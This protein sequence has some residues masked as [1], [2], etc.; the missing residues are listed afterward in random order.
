LDLLE[1][2]QAKATFF[3]IGSR[4]PGNEELLRR[5]LSEGHE[6]GNHLAE[7]EPSV[8]LDPEEFEQKLLDTDRALSNFTS[9]VWFRPGSGWYTPQML[10]ETREHGYTTVMGSVFPF[11]T[12]Y[13]APSFASWYILNH[14]HPGAIIVLHDFG[15][16]TEQT[17]E[18]LRTTIPELQQ[19]GYKFV[20]LSE[21]R[22]ES[23]REE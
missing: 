4:I 19:M 8:A 2:Y 15:D 18:V 3:I 20:T 21:L 11:D 12:Y 9:L 7:E 16:R 6:L 13:R 17:V 23:L 22:I 5:M 14:I 1:Q 10:K